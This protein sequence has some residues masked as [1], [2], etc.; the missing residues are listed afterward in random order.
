MN[1]V[2]SQRKVIV[3]VVSFGRRIDQRP[4]SD[5]THATSCSGF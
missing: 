5:A 3:E 4:E 2:A 1:M